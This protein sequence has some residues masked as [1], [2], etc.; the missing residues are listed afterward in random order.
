[1]SFDVHKLAAVSTVASPPSPAV[2]GTSLVVATG[3]GGRFPSSGSFD[4]VVCPAGESPMWAAGSAAG[5]NFELLRSTRSGDT[6]SFAR[7]QGGTSARTILAGDRFYQPYA[8]RALTDIEN[9]V[10]PLASPDMLPLPFGDVASAGTSPYAMRRDAIFAAPPAGS[11]FSFLPGKWHTAPQ[12]SLGLNAL[13]TT[14]NRCLL[15]PFIPGNAGALAKMSV[16]VW[17][18]TA[19]SVHRLGVYVDDGHG[20]ASGSFDLVEDLG[21]EATDT[22]GAEPQWTGSEDITSS[23]HWVAVTAQVV[24]GMLFGT[25]S[26][27]A[28]TGAASQDAALRAQNVAWFLDGVSGALPDPITGFSAYGDVVLPRVGIKAA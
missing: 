4:V 14:L 15:I 5:G 27:L 2:S 20:G 9:G 3:E 21:T 8:P 23:L 1:M 25:S 26:L 11:F 18:D 12:I 17:G 6:F 28:I 22:N 13:T 16:G 24:A 19:T 10:A 7:A